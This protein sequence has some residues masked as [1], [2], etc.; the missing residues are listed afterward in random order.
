VISLSGY[1]K[2]GIVVPPLPVSVHDL[3]QCLA[4]AIASADKDM[5]WCV[6]NEVDFCIDICHETKGSNVEHSQLILT[7]LKT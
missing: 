2:D 4:I 5:L 7:N 3:K 1:I 6:W